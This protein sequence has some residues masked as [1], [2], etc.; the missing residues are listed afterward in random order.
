MKKTLRLIGMLLFASVVCVGFTACGDDDDDLTSNMPNVVPEEERT[1][2]GENGF[3]WKR[4]GEKAVHGYFETKTSGITLVLSCYRDGEKYPIN[5]KKS[6]VTLEFDRN[7]ISSEYFDDYPSKNQLFIVGINAT[8]VPTNLTIKYK[9]DGKM[10]K[11]IIPITVMNA[12]DYDSDLAR[13]DAINLYWEDQKKYESPFDLKAIS[14]VPV[15]DYIKTDNGVMLLETHSVDVR[16]T[17]HAQ[18]QQYVPISN[19]DIYPGS[20]VII[21]Q[22]L[23]D[24]TPTPYNLGTGGQGTVTVYLNFLAGDGKR[25]AIHN[26]PNEKS[27]VQAAINTLMAQVLGT[28]GKTIVTAPSDLDK[29]STCTN[30]IEEMSVDLNLSAK[31]LGA[32]CN[33]TTN[34]SSKTEKIYKMYTF[35]QSFY[36]IEVEPENDDR[37]NYLG[38][39][40]TV[41]DLKRIEKNYSG[42]LGIIKAVHYGRFGYYC[43]EYESS[44]FSFVGHESISYKDKFSLSSDQDISSFCT[45]TNE[46]SRIYGGSPEEAGEAM[47]NDEMFMKKMLSNCV[48]SYSNQGAPIYYVVEYLGTGGTAIS[49]LTGSYN[50][51]SEY[52]PA[53]S[54]LDFTIENHAGV[55]AGAGMWTDLFYKV[56]EIG[57]DG[58][59][60]DIKTTYKKEDPVETWEK[61]NHGFY[62]GDD[63]KTIEPKPIMLPEG[64]YFRK[65]AYFRITHKHVKDGATQYSSQGMIYIG[66]GHLK[67]CIEGSAYDNDWNHCEDPWLKQKDETYDVLIKGTSKAKRK[68][69][70]IPFK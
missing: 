38:K 10:Y 62:F 68:T 64:Q 43:K 59:P 14:P 63:E 1:G 30:S 57:K 6:D 48:V 25:T 70:K 29:Q 13:R 46:H 5:L 17:Q 69:P 34:S 3:A 41:E 65:E 49:N 28:G 35:N 58:K 32:K 39:R 19:K 4:I 31:F 27:S 9:V 7:Y 26:V 2:N 47:E 52:V 45:S 44:K 37:T 53:P 40:I 11:T 51:I 15:P 20:L 8:P 66:D 21:N 16:D 24:G 12:D 42:K 56:F 18:L 55:P 22:N 61:W 60:V 50:H 33:I 23:A 36:S 67:L 54:R